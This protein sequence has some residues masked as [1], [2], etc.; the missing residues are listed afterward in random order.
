MS[1][2]VRDLSDV[3]RALIQAFIVNRNF[4]AQELRK[5]IASILTVSNQIAENTEDV[6]EI[7]ARDITEEQVDDYIAVANSALYRLD[8]EIRC[9]KDS[10]NSLTWQLVRQLLCA[11]KFC[12]FH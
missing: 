7:R 2:E 10:D 8:F 4:G 1:T 9:S 5:A 12:I 6:P 3:H 11:Y